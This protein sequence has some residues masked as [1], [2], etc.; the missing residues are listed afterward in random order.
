[1]ASDGS[2][3]KNAY[4]IV[5]DAK[6]KYELGRSQ[7]TLTKRD[8]VLKAFPTIYNVDQ[9]GFDTT[10]TLSD[11][12]VKAAQADGVQLVLRYTDDKEGNGKLTADQWTTPFKYDQA[13]NEFVKA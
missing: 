6:T 12:A 3:Y 5:L 9:S 10:I 13:N 4:V 2:G 11:D 7:V 1:M 8:D